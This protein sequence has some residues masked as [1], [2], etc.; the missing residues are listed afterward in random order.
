[1]SLKIIFHCA[2]LGLCVRW[3]QSG[4]IRLDAFLQLGSQRQAPV[5]EQ[6][7]IDL[8]CRMLRTA[9]ITDQ[10]DLAALLKPFGPA[11]LIAIVET[12]GMAAAKT[13]GLAV[14]PGRSVLGAQARQAMAE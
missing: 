12:G 9:G 6:Q 1:M 8:R 3:Q 2:A 11:F 5:I 10:Q 14:Q 7:I 4:D 13:I